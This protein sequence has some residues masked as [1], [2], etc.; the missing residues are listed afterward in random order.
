MLATLPISSLL[1]G[2]FALLQVLGPCTM[3]P[4]WGLALASGERWGW[5]SRS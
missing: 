2:L 3:P 5:S 4:F 1:V